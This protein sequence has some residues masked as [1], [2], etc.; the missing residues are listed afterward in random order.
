MSTGG[1]VLRIS[2][3]RANRS[4]L[5]FDTLWVLHVLE[6]FQGFLYPSGGIASTASTR[7][8]KSILNI[9]GAPV[10]T[11][12]NVCYTSIWIFGYTRGMCSSCVR[13]SSFFLAV[14]IQHNQCPCRFSNPR[15]TRYRLCGMFL[16]ILVLFY[17][18]LEQFFL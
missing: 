3:F 2:Y 10:A 4:I 1:V 11:L 16:F 18:F 12:W 13:G 9:P 15:G 7:G 5:G 14:D 8:T 6:V 17:I